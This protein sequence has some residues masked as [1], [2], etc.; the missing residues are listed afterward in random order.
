MYCQLRK[1]TPLFIGKSWLT[2]EVGVSQLLDQPKNHAVKKLT[3][4]QILLKSRTENQ[5]QAHHN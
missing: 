2:I 4:W 1:A 5:V 3:A